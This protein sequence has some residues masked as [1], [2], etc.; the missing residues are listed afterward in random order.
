MEEKQVYRT[1]YATAVNWC[2]ND[3]VLCNKIPEI[4]NT[5]YDNARFSW[6][7]EDGD[8]IEV[9]QWFITSCSTHDV[10]YLEEQFP[11][12][13]FT[14]SELLEAYILC[15]THWGTG[16]DYVSAPTY[17]KNA[18]CKLGERNKLITY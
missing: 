15:V 18:E 6:E 14:Y 2:H 11:S 10:E 9:Y 12:L 3:F 5:V 1:T 4:D 17:L 13:L 16:W 7:D 8:F